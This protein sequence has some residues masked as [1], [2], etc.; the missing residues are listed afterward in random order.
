[1]LCLDFSRCFEIEPASRKLLGF[2]DETG[3]FRE[4]PKFPFLTKVVVDMIECAVNCLGPDLDPLEDELQR[5][6]NRHI[7]YGVDCKHFPILGRAVIFAMKEILGNKFTRENER[8]WEL[9]FHF[10]VHHMSE[11]MRI[12][13]ELIAMRKDDRSIQ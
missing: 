12:G 7:A 6:G 4:D 11:G 13:K 1:M 5:L 2:Q 3:D 9:V 8:A 10:M